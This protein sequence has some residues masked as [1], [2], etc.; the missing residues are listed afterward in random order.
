MMKGGEVSSSLT[1]VLAMRT[2]SWAAGIACLSVSPPTTQK[3]SRKKGW[4][5]DGQKD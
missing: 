3:R 4:G 2:G 5:M 1:M